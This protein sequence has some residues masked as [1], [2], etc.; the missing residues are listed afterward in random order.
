[1]SKNYL[2]ILLIMISLSEVLTARVINCRVI[3]NSTNSCTPYGS[4][5]LK[6]KEIKYNFDKKKLIVE[7]TLP[8]PA[9]KSS[10]KVISVEEMMK[11]YQ[12]VEDS[13]RFTGTVKS[14]SIQTSKERIYTRIEKIKAERKKLFDKMQK[15]REEKKK[16]QEAKDAEALKLAQAEETKK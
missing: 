13:M 7:K 10:V 9:K 6:A 1:M 14:L 12:P 5:F 15:A 2:T 8:V 3:T 11:K 4:K 16:I